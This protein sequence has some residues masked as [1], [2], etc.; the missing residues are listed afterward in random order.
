VRLVKPTGTAT[1]LA[2][3]GFETIVGVN[4]A[5]SLLLSFISSL[6][7]S[8]HTLLCAHLILS[9]IFACTVFGTNSVCTVYKTS[10][11]CHKSMDIQRTVQSYG[12]RDAKDTIW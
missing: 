1:I 11:S 9:F 6:M 7:H 12:A 4:L 3:F 2:T 8:I 5:P 10:G